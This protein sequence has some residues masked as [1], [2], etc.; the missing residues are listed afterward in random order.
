M[1]KY[2]NFIT[3]LKKCILISMFL[4]TGSLSVILVSLELE[5]FLPLP[6]QF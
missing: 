5:I 2:S 1:E 6:P 4:E 3:L